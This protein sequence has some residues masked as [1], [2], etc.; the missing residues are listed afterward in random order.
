MGLG[1][2]GLWRTPRDKDTPARVAHGRGTADQHNRAANVSQCYLNETPKTFFFIIFD[3]PK[4]YVYIDFF[5]VI[6]YRY[7]QF[8]DCAATYFYKLTARRCHVGGAWQPLLQKGI[9]EDI[10]RKNYSISGRNLTLRLLMHQ[11]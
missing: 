1:W 9:K 8:F 7:I 4:L 10:Y 2:S 3:Y 11:Q 5:I 6:F